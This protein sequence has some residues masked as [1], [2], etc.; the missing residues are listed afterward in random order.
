MRL[1]EAL[2]ANEPISESWDAIAAPDAE[3]DAVEEVENDE[4]EDK[5]DEEDEEI[6]SLV[7]RTKSGRAIKRPRV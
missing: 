7:S 4:N 2:T 5:E 3:N 1:S 6:E